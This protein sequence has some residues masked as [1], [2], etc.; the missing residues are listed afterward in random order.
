MVRSKAPSRSRAVCMCLSMPMQPRRLSGPQVGLRCRLVR[1]QDE[2]AMSEGPRI[3]SRSRR[4]GEA[5]A[6][7]EKRRDGM[8]Y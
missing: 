8:G 6:V 5:G 1:R 7:E 4:C 3:G 2:D